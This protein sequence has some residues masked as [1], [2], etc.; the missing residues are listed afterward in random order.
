MH[1]EELAPGAQVMVKHPL[2]ARRQLGPH[3]LRQLRP[4]GQ[5]PIDHLLLMAQGRQLVCRGGR[6]AQGRLQ[7]GQQ[8]RDR[9]GIGR[10]PGIGRAGS[11]RQSRL[12]G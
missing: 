11:D 10:H 2:P 12:T 6:R 1:G 5:H 4:V 8:R 7:R 9:G 3:Q